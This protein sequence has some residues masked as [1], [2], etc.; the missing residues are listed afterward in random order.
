MEIFCGRRSRKQPPWISIAP[1][2]VPASFFVGG[3][4]D[5]AE[6][7]ETVA[8][9]VLARSSLSLSMHVSWSDRAL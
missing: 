2:H 7:W 6:R 4:W 3:C 1:A 8:P 9:H 5:T